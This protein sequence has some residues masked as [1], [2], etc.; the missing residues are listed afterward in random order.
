MSNEICEIMCSVLPEI[1]VN[2]KKAMQYL[3]SLALVMAIFLVFSCKKNNSSTNDTATIIAKWNIVSDS[4]Y[5]GIVNNHPVNYAG[6]PGDYFDI[7]SD[8]NIYTKEG[9]KFDKLPYH[10]TSDSAID[11]TYYWMTQYQAT[12]T[13]YISNL[14]IHTVTLLDS[15]IATPTGIFGRKLTLRR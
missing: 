12:K 11:I 13:Y 6:V 15:F 8:G 9:S 10:L 4:T 2:V 5:E 7:K 3:R 1:A 14:T